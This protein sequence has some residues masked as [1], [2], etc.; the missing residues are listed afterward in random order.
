MKNNKDYNVNIYYS[1]EEVLTAFTNYYDDV[2]QQT[3]VY[4]FAKESA[5]FSHY[6]K[7]D[8]VVLHHSGGLFAKIRTW[9]TGKTPFHDQLI[10]LEIT[11]ENIK[12]YKKIIANGGTIVISRAVSIES[13][14]PAQ[15]A[16][17]EIL[18]DIS[19][20]VSSTAVGSG[21]E[22]LT[23][24]EKFASTP[25]TNSKDTIP[26]DTTIE[27]IELE[28]V[29]SVQTSELISDV[30]TSKENQL[31]LPPVT[32][33]DAISPT[34]PQPQDPSLLNNQNN[35]SDINEARTN[36]QSFPYD[37]S[38]E[39]LVNEDNIPSHPASISNHS[40]E[41]SDNLNETQVLLGKIESTDAI[42]DA[43]QVSTLN[44][45]Q[46]TNL[47]DESQ[48]ESEH[49]EQISNVQ[50]DISLTFDVRHPEIASNATLEETITLT[51][52]SEL[53]KSNDFEAEVSIEFDASLDNDSNQE[54]TLP[55][56]EEIS[57]E[58]IIE[59]ENIQLIESLQTK[60]E[61][62][63]ALSI[64]NNTSNETNYVTTKGEDEDMSNKESFPRIPEEAKEHPGE[65]LSHLDAYEAAQD[66]LPDSPHPLANLN[67]EEAAFR[68]SEEIG[69]EYP[70]DSTDIN[71]PQTLDDQHNIIVSSESSD[72]FET[73]KRQFEGEVSNSEQNE[74]T[75]QKLVEQES[76][77]VN[78]LAPDDTLHRPDGLED[79]QTYEAIVEDENINLLI[80]E[81]IGKASEYRRHD[82]P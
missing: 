13:N 52:S 73:E 17:Q 44:D 29:G 35:D 67:D 56:V 5:P 66:D 60:E 18:E 46:S 12:K 50:E 48:L 57:S 58:L 39:A 76:T 15:Y 11:S 14:I 24:Q 26:I 65:I 72:Q 34:D 51:N 9:L 77:L 59:N 82:L 71:V 79:Q 42:D 61:N 4:V 53:T 27:P 32:Q 21:T 16:P 62:S 47:Q 81:T 33:E 75:F 2:K 54:A 22:K 1:E 10:Q 8:N 41:A 20:E 25:I 6:T 28:K 69:A 80:D 63:N 23:N 70:I 43:S 3:K 64:E 31:V 38:I 49:V 7:Y 74:E 68:L 78:H 30:T 45:L 19:D 40:T 36:K 37:S 55:L